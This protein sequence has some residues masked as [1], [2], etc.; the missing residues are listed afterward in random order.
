[1][2]SPRFSAA[3]QGIEDGEEFSH[4]GGDDDFEWLTGSMETIGERSQL[5]I[6]SFGRQSRHVQRGS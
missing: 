6:A 3:D 5:L 2:W 1:M 4:A